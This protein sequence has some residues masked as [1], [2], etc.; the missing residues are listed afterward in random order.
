MADANYQ[1]EVVIEAKNK[2][3][4]AFLS[5][6]KE[7][8]SLKQLSDNLTKSLDEQT[9]A[10]ERLNVVTADQEKR[11]KVANS[12]YEDNLVLS[13]KTAAAQR[14]LA[15]ASREYARV[16]AD[17]D[18]EREDRVL[19]I[20]RLQNARTN[21]NKVEL[22][23]NASIILSNAD[24]MASSDKSYQ[25]KVKQYEDEITVLENYEKRVSSIKG[26]LKR[27]DLKKDTREALKDDLTRAVRQLEEKQR[28]IERIEESLKSRKSSFIAEAAQPY[29]DAIEEETQALEENRIE[30]K[31]NQ[32]QD[33][34]TEA[35]AQASAKIR[36]SII[37]DLERE[38]KAIKASGYADNEANKQRIKNIAD[39][40]K[41]YVEATGSIKDFDAAQARAGKLDGADLRNLGT[42]VRGLGTSREAQRKAAVEKQAAVGAGN[43][44]AVIKAEFD[45]SVAERQALEAKQVIEG[46]IG[47]IES[48][49]DLD[50]GKFF[51]AL[52]EVIAAKKILARD[53]NFHISP[54]LD[55]SAVA[56]S[57][58]LLAG[59][60]G[61]FGAIREGVNDA[62]KGVAAFDNLIRGLLVLSIA[63]FFQQ[64]F[65]AVL[66]LASALG[67][68]A[69]SAVAAGGA[70]GGA[71]AAGAAQAIPALGILFAFISRFSAVLNAVKQSNL[72]QQQESYKGA[73]AATAQTGALNGVVSA[74]ERVAEAQKKVTEARIKARKALEDLILSEQKQ[75][76]GLERAKFAL[77]EA[78]A[79][80]AGSLAVAE[81]Q[82]AVKEAT[83]GLGTTRTDIS[84][85][86]AG[87]INGSP[88]V[89][90]AKKALLDAQRALDQAKQSVTGA[91]DSMGAVTGKLDFMTSKLSKSEK[92]L[93]KSIVKLQEDFIGIG[94]KL[95]EPLTKAFTFAVNRIDQILKDSGIVKTGIMISEGLADSF[96]QVFNFILSDETVARFKVFSQQFVD[97]LKPLTSIAINIL[98][99]FYDLAELGAPVLSAI[100]KELDR[101][102][103]KFADFVSASKADGGIAKF[104]D[105]GTDALFKFLQLFG[106]IGKVIIA[107]IGPAGGLKNG[108]KVLDSLI[109]TFNDLAAAIT[110]KD[111]RIG[112]F[113]RKF[114]DYAPRILGVFSGPI[115]A[116]AK[117][118]EGI[119]TPQGF[120]NVQGFADFLSEVLIPAIGSAMNFLGQLTSMFVDLTSSIPGANAAISAFL[121]LLIGGSVL[122]RI[123]A[124]LS[125]FKALTGY[126]FTG[127]G[128]KNIFK[129]FMEDTDKAGGKLKS[130]LQAV[131]DSDG[132]LSQSLKSFATKKLGTTGSAAALAS[133]AGSAVTR[134][135]SVS[136][137]E[138]AAYAADDAFNAA[139]AAF[140]NRETAQDRKDKLKD[141][142]ARDR[143]T[144]RYTK[145]GTMG[146]GTKI[147]TAPKRVLQGAG[148]LGGAE[149]LAAS[150]GL[151]GLAP[152]LGA[153]LGPAGLVAAAVVAI[154]AAVVGLLAISGKLDDVWKAI[155][156]TFS[157]VFSAVKQAL[158]E[159][160][161]EITG[162]KSIKEAFNS[163]VD[164]LKVAGNFLA[165]VLIP[166]IKISGAL[167]GGTIVGAIKAITKVIRFVKEYIGQFK[168]F[169]GAVFDLD[170]GKAVSVLGKMFDSLGKLILGLLA[171]PFEGLLTVVN[172][173]FPEIGKKIEGIFTSVINFF[174][175]GI[176]SVLDLINRIP[177][178]EIEKVKEIQTDEQRVKEERKNTSN[179]KT[180]KASGE[181]KYGRED[182]QNRRGITPA[183]AD[184]K[185]KSPA[186]AKAATKADNAD[187][188]SFLNTFNP[189]T[190][191]LSDEIVKKLS[192]YWRTLRR[193]ARDSVNDV[194]DYLKDLRGAKGNGRIDKFV[195]AAIS[196]FKR[197]R[198]GVRVNMTGVTNIIKNQMQ[199]SMEAVKDAATY[200]QKTLNDALKAVGVKEGLKLTI[201][202]PPKV[203]G[204]AQKAATGGWI[205]NRGERGEDAVPTILGRGEAV[206]NWG[207]QKVVE[208]ALRQVYGFGL[209]EMFG[210]TRS[211]HAG[212]G[213]ATGG[214]ARGGRA[215]SSKGGQDIIATVFGSEGDFYDPEDARDPLTAAGKG[216]RG[217]NMRAIK[218]VY[219]EIADSA[220]GHLARGYK[221]KVSRRGKSAVLG[222]YD[223][224]SYDP[225]DGRKMDIW[226]HAARYLS[227]F[228]KTGMGTV[229]IEPVSQSAPLGPTDGSGGGDAATLKMPKITGA[230]SPIGQFVSKGTKKMMDGAQSYLD[231]HTPTLDVS[232]GGAGTGFDGGKSTTGLIPQVLK[233]I[234]WARGHGWRGQINSG[235]RTFAEQV[236][237]YNRYLNGGNIAAKPGTSNHEFGRAID[238]SDTPGFLRAMQ[239]APANSRLKWYGP[240]DSVHFSVDGRAKGGF[241]GLKKFAHG[242]M[243]NTSS[244][245]DRPYVKPNR[246]N[247]SDSGTEKF[248]GLHVAKWIVPALKWARQNGWHGKITSGFRSVDHNRE[249]GGARG[250]HHTQTKY[251]GGA[252]DVGAPEDRTAGSALA[253]VLRG[254]RGA[255]KLLQGTPAHGNTWHGG[256]Y[257]H[258]SASG[259]AQGGRIN[260]KQFAHGGHV[261]G[262]EGQAVPIIAHAGEWVVNKMQQ[263]KLAMMAGTSP[264]R[265]KGALGFSGGPTSFAGGGS[266]S[267]QS[268]G[269]RRDPYSIEPGALSMESTFTDFAE[270][271]K[272]GFRFINRAVREAL[273]T[274][275]VSNEIRKAEKQIKRLKKGDEN[276]KQKDQIKVLEEVLKGLKDR[277]DFTNLLA[278]IRAL[279]GIDGSGGALGT[280]ADKI[281]KFIDDKTR[282]IQLGAAGFERVG[283]KIK[284]I[285]D[286]SAFEKAI[287]PEQIAKTEASVQEALIEKLTDLRNQ[288]RNALDK[289][290][291]ASKEI[292]SGARLA[293]VIKRDDTKVSDIEEA[294]KKL[295][296]GDESKSEKERIKKLKKQKKD[297]ENRLENNKRSLKVRQGIDS[298]LAAI[299]AKINENEDAIIEAAKAKLEAE[300]TAFTEGTNRLLKASDNSTRSAGWAKSIAELTGNAPG[301]INAL[302]TI[303]NDA[304]TKLDVLN[305][306]LDAAKEKAKTDPRWQSVV[307]DLEQ[308]VGDQ[309]VAVVQ[310]VADAV[311][312]AVTDIEQTFSRS[313]TIRGLKDRAATLVERAGGAGG[314]AEAF[315][316]R[317]ENSTNK[318]TSLSA[319]QSALQNIFDQTANTPENAKIRQDLQDKINELTQAIDENSADTKDLTLEY[320]Q[321]Q[322]DLVTGRASRTTGLLGS[323]GA[324][325]ANIA[326]ATGSTQSTESQIG[327]AEQIKVALGL[328]KTGLIQQVADAM[329]GD[330]FG[331]QA[332]RVNDV[333]SQLQTAFSS[334][335]PNS[336]ATTLAALSPTIAQLSSDLTG[337]AKSAFDSMV[338]SLINNTTATTENTANLAELN[339]LANQPQQFNTTAWTKFRTALFNGVGDILPQFQVP[340]MATGGYITKG[341][342]FQL[343][344][345]EFVVNAQ[346]TNAPADG[347]IN[348]TVNEAN[349]PL[350]VTALASRIAFEKRTRR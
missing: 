80:G 262:P 259:R 280:Y 220:L 87:G 333:F 285:I 17:A 221:L 62:S 81:K 306:R 318:G 286:K 114:F 334:G 42:A 95:T 60:G 231:K 53:V 93:Y 75:T 191:R 316:L 142:K 40:K 20:E 108:Q 195:T 189:D 219:G 27:K 133:A 293:S 251:P 297:L 216:Y 198:T 162:D 327:L 138:E 180:P 301:V 226:I 249:I 283:N 350:D 147:L 173:I 201:S 78:I 206:L 267:P 287:D 230:N 128:K 330:Q 186:K 222:K 130:F 272:E 203:T 322:V 238:V 228:Q 341:G 55:N 289:L 65:V 319:Q 209:D 309:T 149:A 7:F 109:K 242:G 213:R 50:T 73:K 225:G 175:R 71:L 197:L 146:R 165:S 329:S 164:G 292:S 307:D 174:I 72:A 41:S 31:K 204:D 122:G 264:D 116:I 218:W 79:T 178:V 349:K 22:Q 261:E 340:A 148:Y 279:T 227:N 111:S 34:E 120:K 33:K 83:T 282:S 15:S 25:Q 29:I 171:A 99:I 200:M 101:L 311:S 347:P 156:D 346:Q 3:R 253:K 338:D 233:A 67:A 237:L 166:Y 105:A 11:L 275:I 46:I 239:S 9:S 124:L 45:G 69:S 36:K 110:D 74:Q 58:S 23:A 300:K 10:R 59:L 328:E 265:I 184:K 12:L 332:G 247:S 190:V 305:K 187:A 94:A 150:G 243:A 26:R 208:P 181:Q 158:G 51:A 141:P 49:M 269:V 348:I 315:K 250:S 30:K 268:R 324:I 157:N 167:I 136:R 6:G 137:A 98:K 205:G 255:H 257:G 118:I 325:F 344:P 199:N 115:K 177:G 298:E 43:A 290:R 139:E 92:E 102:I 296:K 196:D 48:N 66:G 252:I 169:W 335:D 121:G 163:I 145:K 241:V 284:R 144:G 308:Q 183:K 1:I 337:P 16:E 224:N 14:E 134:G 277:K 273:T 154:V 278:S 24:E 8:D 317:L 210:R 185:D 47:H 13:R 246:D 104:F 212:T 28:E 159:L 313:E 44:D 127:V 320:R 193:A 64:L 235:F 132:V 202:A 57:V 214:F 37:A 143:K 54:E 256:D 21:L 140:P 160:A 161:M 281:K 172:K 63:L 336:F 342:L 263:A 254:Y 123:T 19:A 312:G 326:R 106:A 82:I 270:K 89:T 179:A 68:L 18:A 302:T 236:V 91:A 96:R 188:N 304:K 345:G 223:I 107:L 182:Q 215:G 90:D 85:R 240:G 176:N 244:A 103:K 314:P 276:D 339:G 125:P 295:E 271:I 112:I 35:S 274:N 5:V 52:P 168:E 217:D 248:N 119:F 151:E 56:K 194:I 291:T 129:I 321:A 294:I 153:A 232:A 113:F 126:L 170:I 76:I 288:Y 310:T 70:L 38:T 100:L 331:T 207:H 2:I 303:A 131:I 258:F 39:L 343:H 266:P 152:A 234:A 86:Q 97:N 323:A 61:A 229:H 299:N 88:E 117:I 245:I 260:I 135:S 32:L 77:S 4:D 155:T 84:K 192:S 211:A